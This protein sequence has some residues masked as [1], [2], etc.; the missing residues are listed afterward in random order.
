M[1]WFREPI[2]PKSGLILPAMSTPTA[3]TVDEAGAHFRAVLNTALRRRGWSRN[4]LA[5]EWKAV[6]PDA[7]SVVQVYR[8]AKG[9]AT[10]NLSH[11]VQ[12][13][14]LFEIPSRVFVHRGHEV[15]RVPKSTPA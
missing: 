7:P 10:P 8:L 11:L 2:R 4:R 15:P 1:Q 3:P 12:L 5:R 13:G 14:E 6:H 9:P